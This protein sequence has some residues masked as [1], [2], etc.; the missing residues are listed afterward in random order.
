MSDSDIQQ[1]ESVMA[2]QVARLT[3]LPAPSSTPPKLKTGYVKLY[4]DDKFDGPSYEIKLSKWK[5]NT[6]HRLKWDT[7]DNATWVAWNLPLGTVV[8]LTD[9]V[10]TVDKGHLLA[11]LSHCGRCVDL[12]G[13]GV[14]E[15]ADLRATDTND[16][17][18]GFFW[19]EVDLNM[20]AI[21]LFDAVKWNGL[22]RST[23]FLSEWPP[24]VPHSILDWHINDRISSARWHTLRDRQQATL[25]YDIGNG[26]QFDNIQGWGD[27]EDKEEEDFRDADHN[28][29]FT[30]FQ[31]DAIVPVREEILPLL[32]T[33][34]RSN[35]Q[36]LTAI[37]SEENNS[38]QVQ[39]SKV[40]LID[41]THQEVTVETTD[42]TVWGVTTT[43]TN[44]AKAGNDN[45]A[46]Y[47]ST[48]ELS[49][50]FDYTKTNTKSTKDAKTIT[51]SLEE[52]FRVSPHSKFTARVEAMM[53]KIPHK[54]YE[55]KATRWYEHEVTG[56]TKDGKY[57]K[58]VEPVKLNVTGS[59]HCEVKKFYN[60]SPLPGYEGSKVQEIAN[61]VVDKGQ[62][63]ANGATN[64]AHEVMHKVPG[65]KGFA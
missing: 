3:K 14:T 33:P 32:I 43:L 45:F 24:G 13:S 2:A 65:L 53:G 5:K 7:F 27:P 37:K 9:H 61:N 42:T 44:S 20:G 30:S 17:I 16:C 49:V 1:D 18:S 12:V 31:W 52:G 10:T 58:R 21:E 50:R 56:A 29:K 28:D 62:D 15:A 51:L 11:D 23:I 39:E 6:R 46:S 34:D 41:T 54:V 64:K 25:F 35:S 59:L 57:Y 26:G 60:E 8:T 55:T 4:A 48:F 19:R 47:E 22:N 40:T 63:L 38:N 36:P